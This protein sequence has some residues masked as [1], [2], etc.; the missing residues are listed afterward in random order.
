MNMQLITFTIAATISALAVSAQEIIT[1]EVGAE[2]PAASTELTT[3]DGA[4][5][6]LEALKGK[7]GTLVIFSCNTCPFVVG[8]DDSEGWENRYNQVTSAAKE[9][10]VNTV[11]INSNEAKREKGDGLEDM[12]QRKA[13][14]GLTAEYVLDRNSVVADA[15]GARTTPHV[16]LFD[17]TNTLVYSGAIDDNVNSAS[18]VKE[19]WLENA[20]DAMAKGEKI[21]P[22]KTRNKGCSI[23]RL[24]A[25]R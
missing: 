21:D 15:F 25:S 18:D 3:S 13:E 11:L 23:K 6:S 24:N 8:T 1:L 9:K 10:G 12:T 22:N 19:R 2:M 5:T 16:F 17:K 20:L 7:T 14:R 4:S